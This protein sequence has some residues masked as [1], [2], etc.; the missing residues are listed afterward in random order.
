MNQLFTSIVL[1]TLMTSY[2]HQVKFTA[3]DMKEIRTNV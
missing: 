3:K 2:N 1:N